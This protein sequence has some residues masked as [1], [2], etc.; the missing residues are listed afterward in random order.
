MTSEHVTVL[1]M[2]RFCYFCFAFPCESSLGLPSPLRLGF[3]KKPH[4]SWK[5]NGYQRIILPPTLLLSKS[6]KYVV[7]ND[8]SYSKDIKVNQSKVECFSVLLD[9]QRAEPFKLSKTNR[10]FHSTFLP[11]RQPWMIC[12]PKFYTTFS[13]GLNMSLSNLSIYPISKWFLWIKPDNK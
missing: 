12:C 6:Q 8:N 4:Q 13:R 1:Q 7:K 10:I 11:K 9:T 5:R 2:Q 3:L